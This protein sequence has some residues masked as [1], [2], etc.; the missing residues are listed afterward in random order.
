MVLILVVCTFYTFYKSCHTDPGFVPFLASKQEQYKTIFVLCEEGKFN[1]S[2]F[3]TSCLVRRPIRS[4]HCPACKRCIAR[5]DHHCPWVNNCIG[6]K[7]HKMF[8]AYIFCLLLALIWSIKSTLYY[9]FN[10]YPADPSGS[11]LSRCWHYLVADPWAGFILIMSFVHFTW[12][13]LLLMSQLFQLF[14]QGMTTNEKRNAHRY[15]HFL[16][17]GGLS[18][19]HRGACANCADFFGF[20]CCNPRDKRV[21]WTRTYDIPRHQN[22][23]AMNLNEEDSSR[24]KI[25]IPLPYVNPSN[26]QSTSS[27]TYAS[28]S[29]SSIPRGPSTTEITEPLKES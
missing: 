19:F 6:L 23:L 16:K 28:D 8:L 9:M 29:E 18:P 27:F 4:K 14:C 13:Y 10:F 26:H 2:T 21:D 20:T 3:C 15:E 5:F 1:N 11:L 22:P 24:P 12:V 17:L 7:N 25:K